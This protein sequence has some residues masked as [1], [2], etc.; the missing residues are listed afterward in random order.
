[1]DV[2]GG[3]SPAWGHRPG[4]SSYIF[5]QVLNLISLVL[6]IR[7]GVDEGLWV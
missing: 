3:Q 5:R 4:I 7:P 6:H 1:M 2:E